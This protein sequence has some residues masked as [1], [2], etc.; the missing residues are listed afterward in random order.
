[1]CYLILCILYHIVECCMT[2]KLNILSF[3]PATS[4]HCMY[5]HQRSTTMVRYKYM[6][7]FF[8]C[9]T[10]VRLIQP[11]TSDYLDSWQY[12]LFDFTLL[13]SPL[14]TNQR[15]LCQLAYNVCLLV[16]RE[17]TDSTVHFAHWHILISVFLFISSHIN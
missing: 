15:H 13:I 2:H 14:E 4:I 17:R 5:A 1:M 16:V 11:F 7:I 8:A 9:M 3:P 12:F 6:Y 10:A